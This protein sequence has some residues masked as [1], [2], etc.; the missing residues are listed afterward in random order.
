M[1]VC[2]K[3]DR[4]G[5]EGAMSRLMEGREVGRAGREFEGLGR[6]TRKSKKL[7]AGR[8]AGNGEGRAGK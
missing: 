1:Q 5:R 6:I 3:G 2:G 7:G 4:E 8:E